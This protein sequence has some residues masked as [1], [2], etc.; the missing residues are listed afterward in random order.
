MAEEI[1]SEKDKA[2]FVCVK[3]T[4]DGAYPALVMGINA[5]R[6]GMETIIFYSFMGLNMLLRK[7]AQKARFYPPGFLGSVPGMPAIASAMMKKKV[8][9]ANIP[10][11]EDMLEMVRLEGVKLVACHMSVEMMALEQDE[12][13]DGVE[14]WT[15]ERFMKY[16]Q[17]C[18]VCLFT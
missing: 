4:L 14:V 16:A 9:R 8:E 12:F 17:E 1:K 6:T 11:L 18:K 2:V 10:S 13:I 5:A 7:G 15:A 3:D